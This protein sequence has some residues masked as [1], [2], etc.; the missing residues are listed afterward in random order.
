MKKPVK[1]QPSSGEIAILAMLWQ[2]GPLS[3]AQAH[4]RFGRYGRPVGYPT[5]QT[6]LNRLAAK[7]WVGR[8][9]ER[10]SLY[11]ASVTADEVAAGHLDQWLSM[12]KTAGVALL[13]A[14]LIAESPLTPK[15]I[16]E[17]RRLLTE[18]EKAA[19]K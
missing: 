7:G 15:E 9:D 18:A 17:L 2:E 10:P 16:Q 6:R 19:R 1:V 11:S 3:L 12:A 13:V 4:Q 8:S 5:M 14:H